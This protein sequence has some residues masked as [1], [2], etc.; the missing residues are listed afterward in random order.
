MLLYTK[1]LM[2]LKN[3]LRKYFREGELMRPL[4]WEKA[5]GKYTYLHES[6]KYITVDRVFSGAYICRDGLG[7]VLLV[8]PMLQTEKIQPLVQYPG[9]VFAL[10]EMN[11]E[12]PRILRRRRPAASV[13]Y[14]SF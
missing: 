1:Q 8:N 10:C 5:P 11:A 4:K 3:G 13:A 12:K 7:I 14:S 9:K 2:H 6:G